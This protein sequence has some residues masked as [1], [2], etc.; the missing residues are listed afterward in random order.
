V[1]IVRI[2]TPHDPSLEI[3]PRRARHREHARR[4]VLRTL[5]EVTGVAIDHLRFMREM[6]GKPR[7]TIGG[8]GEVSF[9]VSHAD[10]ASLLAIA[11]PGLDVGVDIERVID[12]PDAAA[13]AARVLAPRERDALTQDNDQPGAVRALL[14]RW[15]EKEAIL[16]AA[17][18]GL[19]RDPQ[20][21]A[22]VS[23]SGALH[24]EGASDL[25]HFRVWPLDVG[26]RFVA[27]VSANRPPLTVTWRAAP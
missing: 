23:R 10:G 4:E 24:A 19:S 2:E 3:A 7:L 20:S 6:S 14:Q 26:P 5:S 18:L 8:T 21:F 17:G 11:E 9:N 27:A 1:L 16:K 12:L 22:L 25:R 13:L 15:T